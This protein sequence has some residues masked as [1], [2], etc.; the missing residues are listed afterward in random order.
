V[1]DVLE[2]LVRLFS[3]DLKAKRFNFNFYSAMTLLFNHEA[4]IHKYHFQIPD[5]ELKK[6]RTAG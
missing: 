1:G 6:L 4:V 3:L 5:T 2:V